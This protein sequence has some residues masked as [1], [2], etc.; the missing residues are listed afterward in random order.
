M[1]E[2]FKIKLENPYIYNSWRA[3]RY[4]QK[5]KKI[6]N[7]K[8]WDDFINF[9]NDVKGDYKKGLRLARLDK[10]KPFS[11]NNFIWVTPEQAVRLH[12]NLVKLTYNGETLYLSEL[13]EKYDQSLSGVRQRYFRHKDTYTV[14]EII[15]G[16]KKSKKRPAADIKDLPDNLKRAKASKM[17]SS[18][19]IKDKKRDLECDLTIE[20][21]LDIMSKPCVYCGDTKRIGCD[22]LDNEKGHTKDNVVPCC[23]ECNKARNN[24]FSFEEMQIIG[25]A[26]REVKLKRIK[27]L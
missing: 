15:F 3:I 20:D 21:M 7:S 18:Y 2:T 16:K 4:T 22:R 6:G 9:F 26:I 8:E 13:A 14:E 1:S 25:K 24:N 5:G 19:R 11:K 17:L 23:V 27:N 12:D 10:T